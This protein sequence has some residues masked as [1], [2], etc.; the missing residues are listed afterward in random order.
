M[1]H[2]STS[3]A[4]PETIGEPIGTKIEDFDH[5]KCIFFFGQNVRVNLDV[6]FIAQH[7]LRKNCWL[8]SRALAH[9]LDWPRSR[10]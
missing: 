3:V 2:E 8:I 9:L 10:T 4:L 6:D 7:R 1:C 5:T